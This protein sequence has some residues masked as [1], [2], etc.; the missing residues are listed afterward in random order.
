MFFNIKKTEETTFTFSQV[1]YKIQTQKTVNLLND[2]G[3]EEPK[4]ATKSVCQRLS[5]K[6]WVQRKQSYQI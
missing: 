5:N 6:K 3:N 1:S 4:F 2:L